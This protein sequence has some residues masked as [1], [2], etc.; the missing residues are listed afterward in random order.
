MF[1]DIQ[2]LISD[3]DSRRSL[4]FEQMKELKSL[5]QEIKQLNEEASHNAT[6]QCKLKK[7]KQAFPEGIDK[8]QKDI[9]AKINLLEKNFKVIEKTFKSINSDNGN[10]TLLGSSAAVNKKRKTLKS[11]S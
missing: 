2:A 7:L 1:N 9:F 10:K 6:A 4:L 3:L 8:C 5:Q 11:Y